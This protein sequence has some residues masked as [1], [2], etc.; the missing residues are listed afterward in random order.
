VPRKFKAPRSEG[1]TDQ[2]MKPKKESKA[3][4]MMEMKSPKDGMTSPKMKAG[5]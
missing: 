3:A 1:E 4:D 5:G 2:K